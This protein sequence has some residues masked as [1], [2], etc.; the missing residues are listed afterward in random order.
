MII[1]L[2]LGGIRTTVSNDVA[3]L[4]YM[5]ITLELG[6]IRTTQYVLHLVLGNLLGL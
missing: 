4:L 2:E 3:L 1:T 5:I 6:G